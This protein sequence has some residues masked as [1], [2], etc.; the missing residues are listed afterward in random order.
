MSHARNLA[1]EL[2]RVVRVNA[3]VRCGKAER[4]V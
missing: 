3:P 1:F 2:P 4:S